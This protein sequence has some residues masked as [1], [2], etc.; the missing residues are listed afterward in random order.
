M[1]EEQFL[2]KVREMLPELNELIMAK[3]Q[4]VFKSGAIEPSD[5]EDNYLLPKIFISAMGREIERQY[6]PFMRQDV[7]TRNNLYNFL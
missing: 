3:A 6:K 4:K 7:S 1:T 2:E 5:Y